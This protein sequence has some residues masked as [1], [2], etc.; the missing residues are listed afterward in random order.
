MT[1]N[2]WSFNRIPAKSRIAIRCSFVVRSFV[3]NTHS[4]EPICSKIGNTHSKRAYLLLC[5]ARLSVFLSVVL[6]IKKIKILAWKKNW[7]AHFRI[8][9]AGIECSIIWSDGPWIMQTL[10]DT[11]QSNISYVFVT[12]WGIMFK[13]DVYAVKRGRNTG[14]FLTCDFAM[15]CYSV[16]PD[17]LLISAWCRGRMPISSERI[18]WRDIQIVQIN[19]RGRCLAVY[20]IWEHRDREYNIPFISASF[21][22]S[23]FWIWVQDNLSFRPIMDV[24]LDTSAA[25][26]EVA[27]MNGC[28]SNNLSWVPCTLVFVQFHITT[29][30]L[31]SGSAI[32]SV[33][34]P[35]VHNFLG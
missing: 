30:L 34:T 23:F 9:F 1:F 20:C 33:S 26:A 35:P 25:G 4:N 32:A 27:S 11:V 18:C 28:D 2:D 6:L 24:G 31:F 12:T 10:W 3:F 16:V 21:T 29:L 14:I 13:T 19:I 17:L 7:W 22:K 5:L 8:N 15:T